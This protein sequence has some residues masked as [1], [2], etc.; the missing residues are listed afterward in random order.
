MQDSDAIV[1]AGNA[2]EAGQIIECK[3]TGK[4][5][6]T[7][8]VQVFVSTFPALILCSTFDVFSSFRGSDFC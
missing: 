7:N 2:T 5:G 3:V 8:K 1:I 6:I 4:D